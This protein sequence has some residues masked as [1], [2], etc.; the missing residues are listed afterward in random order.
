MAQHDIRDLF[1]QQDVTRVPDPNQTFPDQGP[2]ENF[3]RNILEGADPT[4]GIATGAAGLRPQDPNVPLQIAAGLFTGG[5]LVRG[6]KA[7]VGGL[8]GVLK[9]IT[10]RGGSKATADRL[11]RGSA[12]G[13]IRGTPPPQRVVDQIEAL[14]RRRVA[15]PQRRAIER[16]RPFVERLKRAVRE[17]RSDDARQLAREM[18]QHDRTPLPR[19]R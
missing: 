14:A 12:A 6:G 10:G 3:L 2:V 1:A 19:T 9:R 7:A 11:T 13:I 16:S 17:G 18:I 5:S 15:S 4:L 8:V